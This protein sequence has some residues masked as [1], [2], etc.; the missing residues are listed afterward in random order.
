MHCALHWFYCQFSQ[1]LC[2][3]TVNNSQTQAEFSSFSNLTKISPINAFVF[4]AFTKI[5]V[6][7][8]SSVMRDKDSKDILLE[9]E[10]I[11]LCNRANPRVT[12]AD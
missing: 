7:Y 6:I 2:P 1:S 12:T 4:I 3:K 9:K 8:R 11:E 5:L 10:T